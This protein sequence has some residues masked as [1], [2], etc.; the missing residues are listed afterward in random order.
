MHAINKTCLNPRIARWILKLQNYTFK[1][2]H[3]EARRMAHV[4]A[5][6]R[7]VCFTDSIPLEKELQYRQLQDPK[8]KAIAENLEGRD[9][10]EFELID[11]LVFKKGIYKH[12][13][14]VPDTMISNIIRV[15]HDDMA[16]CGFEKT[17]QGIANNYWFPSFRK[18]IR[19]HID[20]CL[21]CLTTNTSTNSQEG[22]LQRTDTP[23]FPFDICHIDH[24]GPIKESIDGFKYILVLIDVFSRFT[25]LTDRKSVV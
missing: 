9:H 13:F 23:S 25:W 20:N 5:L 18:R 19:N 24:F 2:K 1:T 4:D 7:A 8:L 21:I 6:S 16:H 15:Y 10:D 22:E 17:V 14:V 3:R 11:G 12:R